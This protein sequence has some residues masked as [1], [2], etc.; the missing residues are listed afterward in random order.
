[1]DCDKRRKLRRRLSQWPPDLWRIG[2][3]ITACARAL[4]ALG[5]ERGDR[6][7]TLASPGSDFLV[8]FLATVRIGAMWVGLNPVQQL[9]EYRHILSDCRPKVLFAA[10]TLRGR[11]NLAIV[12]QLKDEFPSLAA[13]VILDAE[14]SNP[15]SY[16]SF[17]DGGWAV[18]EALVA[19][20][21]QCLE[22]DDGALIV[23][24][25]GTTGKPKGAVLTQ[26]NIA[27]SAAAYCRLWP[28]VP[29]RIL[30][31]LPIS[32]VACCVE[33]AAFAMA[34]GG[35]IVFQD[36]FDPEAYLEAIE[37]ERVTFI[38]LV[39]TMFQR[40][41][42]LGDWQRYDTSSL[43]TILFGGAAMPI[44]MIEKLL[45]L[46]KTVVNCWGMTRD[47]LRHHLHRTR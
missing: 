34:A 17:V 41:L 7:A 3:Q 8:T 35:T 9:D 29:L 15:L 13:L 2:G 20:R 10:T 40:I 5:V 43:E 38:P 39:P 25:S 4:V 1:M 46:G 42:A 6:V 16:R 32:H 24:T 26:A 44:D 18:P 36:Q 22:P 19:A 30:C 23:Y 33:T 28:H 45:R 12:A 47:H 14:D 21:V 11:N 37:Q 27:H 31:N